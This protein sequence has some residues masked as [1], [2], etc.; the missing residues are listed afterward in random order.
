[1]TPVREPISAAQIEAELTSACLLRSYKGL[2]IYV[3][4][5]AATPEIM[6]E[7]GRI[8]EREF[9]AEG[10]GTGKAVDIDGFDTEP[11]GFRQLFCYD[12]EYGEIVSMYRFLYWGSPN[13]PALEAS[14]PTGRLFAF[15]DRFKRDFLPYAMELGRSVVNRSAHRALVGLF[16]VWA[17]LGAIVRECPELGYFFGK[18]TM[19]PRYSRRAR[20]AL[21][22]FLRCYFPDRDRLMMPMP[23][24]AEAPLPEEGEEIV[25]FNTGSYRTDFDVLK[26]R[27]AE[28]GE[29]LPPLVI[30]Y[31]GLSE[32]MR[33]FGTAVNPSFGS[34]LESAILISIA[35]IR[36]KQ[37][38][39]FIESYDAKGK[40]ELI[41]GVP[42]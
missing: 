24:V 28:L 36:Q 7:I 31:T 11:R 3:T 13:A 34:V 16:A 38:S 6:Q 42:K 27:V 35:D 30:S 26:A 40:Y 15:S 17:G 10:G 33:F 4:T 14:S 41:A 12:P 5:A 39:R 32:T 9:R 22:A 8:R 37:R 19:Y 2:D 29:A 1:M 20:A 18:F 21:F 25:A 23:D